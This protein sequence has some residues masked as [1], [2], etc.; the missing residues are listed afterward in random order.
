MSIHSE[1]KL[2]RKFV[3]FARQ[4]NLYLNHFPKHEKYGLSLQIRNAAYDVYGYVVESQKRYHKKTSLTN[5][6]IRHEQLRMLVRLAFELGYFE[7]N[8]G[9]RGEGGP[10]QLAVKRYTALS[11][12]IDE[13]GRMIGGWLNTELDKDQNRNK[14]K[15]Q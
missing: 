9:E 2:D 13:L 5:L 12:M 8:N 6:D 14:D 3:D 15:E 10:E 1:A 4:M 11:S 7:F